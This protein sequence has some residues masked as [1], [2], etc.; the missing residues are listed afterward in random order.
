MPPQRHFSTSSERSVSSED[1]RECFTTI[2]HVLPGSNARI[3][4]S[5]SSLAL[6][7][8]EIA[9]TLACHLSSFALAQ[10]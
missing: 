4:N 2:N 3:A 5:A 7:D 9:L 1:T 6:P 10:E 8:I